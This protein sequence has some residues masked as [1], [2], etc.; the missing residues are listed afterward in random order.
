MNLRLGDVVAEIFLSYSR[1]DRSIAESIANELRTLGIDIWWDDEL[2]GGEDFR[3]RISEILSKVSLVIVLWSQHSVESQFVINEAAVGRDAG[4]LI[5]IS[6]DGQQPPIDFR[7]LHTISLKSWVPGDELTRRLQIVLGERLGRELSYGSERHQTGP[8]GRIAKQ[9]SQAWYSDFESILF[10][11]VGQGTACVL[12]NFSIA[13]LAIQVEK[14]SVHL[15]AWA[16]YAFSILAG[17][18]IAPLYMRPLLAN[19]RLRIAVPL[20]M[21]STLMSVPAYFVAVA[22][23]EQMGNQVI[24]LLG[25][26]TWLLLLITTL[27]E[28]AA[29]SKRSW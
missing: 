9:A 10:Y 26:T 23:L 1:E 27:A 4:K 8:I 21:A 18:L 13:F 14:Q 15:P 28:R 6:I 22:L 5:P 20:F 25:P 16:N 12:C 17:M 3:H 19:S 11:L 29:A 24:L 7:G 2:Y